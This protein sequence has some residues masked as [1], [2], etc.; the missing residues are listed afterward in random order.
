MLKAQS[1]TSPPA[2]TILTRT[3]NDT[4]CPWVSEASDYVY[5]VRIEMRAKDN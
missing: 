3:V 2:W 1:M 5:W 4:L